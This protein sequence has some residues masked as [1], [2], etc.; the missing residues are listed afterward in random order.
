MDAI[1]EAV[2]ESGIKANLSRGAT[3][4]LGDEFDDRSFPACKELREVTRKWNGYDDGRIKIEGSRS[5][6][7][8]GVS[9]KDAGLPE[10]DSNGRYTRPVIQS[11]DMTFTFG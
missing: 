1:A 2:A 10:F 5:E 9:P 11:A 6:Y 3:M 8:F 7:L 4:L